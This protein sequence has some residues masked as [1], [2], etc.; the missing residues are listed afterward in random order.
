MFYPDFYAAQ[1]EVL[2]SI[3][4]YKFEGVWNDDLHSEEVNGY[5][6]Y[7]KYQGAAYL[8][9]DT[10]TIGL[11]GED[12]MIIGNSIPEFTANW[13]TLLHYKQFTFEQY[14]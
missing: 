12:K 7:D 6:K 14:W 9:G 8:N 3:T 11:N 2:G 5:N 1:N 13:I 10:A 4:G